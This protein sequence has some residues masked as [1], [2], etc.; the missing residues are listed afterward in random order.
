MYSSDI[1]LQFTLGNDFPSTGEIVLDFSGENAGFSINTDQKCT[2]TS[3]NSNLS[4]SSS[5]DCQ[6]YAS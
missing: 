4:V 1:D 3:T 2:I 6:I 5:V